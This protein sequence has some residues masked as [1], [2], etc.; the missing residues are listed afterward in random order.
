MNVPKISILAPTFNHER[1]I[2][3]FIESCLSQTFEN[4][5]LILVDDCSSDNNVE[6]IKKFQDPRIQLIRHD[7]NRGINATLNTAFEYAKGEFLVF[8]AGDDMF[9]SYALEILNTALEEN[10]N[11]KA[12]YPA[13]TRIDRSNKRN[14]VL[15]QPILKREKILHE[16]F[17]NRN[18]LFSPGLSLRK[19][20]FQEILY[21]LDNA[22][23]N[24]QDTQ[25]GIKLLLSGEIVTFNSPLI[26]Y[27]F[28]KNAN[29]ISTFFKSNKS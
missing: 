17:M 12:I 23:C 5:E 19:K 20:D 29:N 10:P 22:M 8:L 7:F 24:H 18:I 11:A 15:N 25:M 16:L 21:P 2:K 14:E 26:L 27:R 28:D 1:Y 6:E 3:F 4:F 9:E 13:L